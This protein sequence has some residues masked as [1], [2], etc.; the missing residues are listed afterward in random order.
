MKKLLLCIAVLTFLYSCGKKDRGELVG[1]PG[2]KVASR[3]A[4][5]DD[6]SARRFI[7]YG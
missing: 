5:R 7:Y 2:K 1:A 4:L 3:K 6:I